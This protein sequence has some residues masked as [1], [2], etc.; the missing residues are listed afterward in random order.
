MGVSPSTYIHHENGT[1]DFGEEAARMYARK[2][3]VTLEWLLLG[4]GEMATPDLLEERE[5]EV[6]ARKQEEEEIRAAQ[7]QIPK[8][9]K[10]EWRQREEQRDGQKAIETL[11]TMALVP[12]ISAQYEKTSNPLHRGWARF[13]NLTER[14]I[15]PIVATWG[16]PWNHLRYE[17]ASDPHESI[18]FQIEGSANA[19]TLMHGDL[20]IV[21]TTIDDLVA[22][23]FYLIADKVGY[24]QVRRLQSNLYSDPPTVRI[25]ADATPADVV[26]VT[27]ETLSI[28]GRV[29]GKVSRL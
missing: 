14:V 18:L 2:Y 11:K 21:D 28:V 15:H 24:P 8:E 3:H 19:P 20:V 12:E 27:L 13:I 4:Q 29:R 1:R 16:I 6:R 25:T 7:A 9:V 22:D 17:F 26:T 10:Q 23:G 5:A